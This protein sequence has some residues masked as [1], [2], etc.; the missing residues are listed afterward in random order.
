[1]LSIKAFNTTVC[2][3][4]YTASKLPLRLAWNSNQ[5]NIK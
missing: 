1:V 4:G 5:R 2:H 3:V